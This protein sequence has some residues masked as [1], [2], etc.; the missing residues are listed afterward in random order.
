M[1]VALPALADGA[2]WVQTGTVGLPDVSRLGGMA[3]ARGTPFVDAPVLGTR[4]PAEDGALVVLAAGLPEH[5][6]AV[7]LVFDAIGS[8]TVVV[9]DVPGAGTRL[10]LAVN[11]WVQTIT[12]GT[13]QSVAACRGLGVDPQLFLDAI[14]GTA[15]D[16]RYAH[17]KGGAMIAG[18][19]PPAFGLDGAVKD[20]GLIAAALAD[21]GVDTTLMAAVG[22]LFRRAADAGHGGE[23]MAAVV[24]SFER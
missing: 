17:V 1:D 22:A 4:G 2:V 7:A 10:K 24:H 5:R 18:E 20:S 19:F 9:G 23:D 13:A 11:A 6:R 14:A 15:T 3:A 21:A 8:R 12:A 16:S